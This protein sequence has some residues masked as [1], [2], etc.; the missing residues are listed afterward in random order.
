MHEGRPSFGCARR[1]PLEIDD[2]GPRC[3]A[4]GA[5]GGACDN[6]GPNV[7]SVTYVKTGAGALQLSITVTGAAANTSYTVYL[8]CGPTHDLAC[9]F[10]SVG[11]VTTDGAGNAS[12]VIT[13]SA[14]TLQTLHP[15]PGTHNDHID[16][17]SGPHTIA[18]TP[19]GTITYSVP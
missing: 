18:T 6:V 5:A 8:T 3:D 15:T 17:L 9:G 7:G 13:V 14:A 16:L 12:T 4:G 1:T 19:T 2:R 10:V 11:T